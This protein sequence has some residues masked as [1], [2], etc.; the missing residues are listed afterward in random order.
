[1][2]IRTAKVFSR[3]FSGEDFAK[4]KA[5]EFTEWV[6]P[7]QEIL[8]FQR[9]T[10]MSRQETPPSLPDWLFQLLSA[11]SWLLGLPRVR[12]SLSFARTPQVAQH[13]PGCRCI[14]S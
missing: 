9:E 6:T 12:L 4:R 10:L 13:W 3:M 5:D 14:F 8:L 1:M 2:R 7:R 11:D